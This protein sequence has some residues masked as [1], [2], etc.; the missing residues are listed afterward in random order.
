MKA[1]IKFAEVK[2]EKQ[3]AEIKAKVTANVNAVKQEAKQVM[4]AEIKEIKNNK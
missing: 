2:Y 3:L 1:T 4:H